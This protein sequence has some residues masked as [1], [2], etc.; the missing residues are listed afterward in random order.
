[1][2]I[3]EE[4]RMTKI[5]ECDN[6][7]KYFG[8]LS[9]VNGVCLG[10]NEG[11]IVGLI[12][13]NGAGKTTLFNLITGF[14]PPSSGEICFDGLDIT[15]LPPYVIAKRGLV[16][17][18][19]KI[20]LFPNLSVLENVIIGRYL[21]IKAGFLRAL[22]QSRSKQIEKKLSLNDADRILHFLGLSK[23]KEVKASNLPLGGLQKILGI[24]VALAAQPKLLLLDEPASGMNTEEKKTIIDIIRK[25]SDSGITIFVVEHDMNVVMNLC[26]RVVVLDY[27]EVIAEG[28]PESIQRD[29][30]VIEV[31]LGKGY[32]HDLGIS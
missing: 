11:E 19:Q 18:F 27:G 31:Y 28:T 29:P 1:L 13:P 6:L 26:Q 12:G 15:G 22:I 25:I 23:W 3:S 14:L 7:S 16:R 2:Y 9:A 10:I 24:A 32:R 20:T 8:G 4:G 21:N 5:L 17:T 30:K